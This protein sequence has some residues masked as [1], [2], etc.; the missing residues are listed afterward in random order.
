M[1]NI[2]RLEEVTPQAET[3]DQNPTEGTVQI[4]TDLPGR[5]LIRVVELFWLNKN[6]DMPITEVYP[7]IDQVSDKTIKEYEDAGHLVDIDSNCRNLLKIC[8]ET[9]ALSK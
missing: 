6:Y 2:A 8:Q 3:H 4:K 1:V 5:T 9:S 7:R